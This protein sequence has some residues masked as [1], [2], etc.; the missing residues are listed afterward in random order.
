MSAIDL[1][2][3]NIAHTNKSAQI[4]LQI[5]RNTPAE[6]KITIQ[7]NN[8][9]KALHPYHCAEQNNNDCAG[10]HD[11]IDSQFSMTR[12]GELQS[13][14]RTLHIRLGFSKLMW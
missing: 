2:E 8:R 14:T 9:E 10:D 12:C 7:D 13:F 6:Q 5:A 11:S 4:Y 3:P 1:A